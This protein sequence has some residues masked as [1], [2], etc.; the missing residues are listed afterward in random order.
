MWRLAAGNVIGCAVYGT[1]SFVIACFVG[2]DTASAIAS[3]LL[4]LSPLVLLAKKERL[5]HLRRDW[6]RAKGKLQGANARKFVTFSYYAFFFIVFWL[7]FEQVM[8]EMPDGIYTGGSQNL[9]DLPFHLGA[10]FSFTDGG[11]F[12]PQNPSFAGAKFSYPFIADVITAGFIKLGSDV[13]E[14]MFAQN[15]SWALSLLVLLDRFVAKLTGERSVGK[16]AVFLLFFSGGLGFILFAGDFHAQSKGFWEF[17]W[18]LPKDYTIG[19]NYSWGNSLVTLF[20]TQRSLLLGMPLTLL[21]LNFLWT[22]F[23]TGTD[24]SPELLRSKGLD[25]SSTGHEVHKAPPGVGHRG[26]M[27][28]LGNGADLARAFIVGLIAGCLPLI[29]LHSLAVVFVVTAFLFI[30]RPEQWRTW[31]S[32]GVGVSAIAVPELAWSLL[33]SASKATEFIGWH[34]GWTIKDENVLWFWTRNTGILIPLTILGVLIV[35]LGKKPQAPHARRSNAEMD[36]NKS[37]QKSL[38]FYLPFLFCFIIANITKLAPWEWDNIKVLIYWLLGSLPFIS[39]AIVWAWRQNMVLKVC[40]AMCFAAMIASGSLD[41]WRT[42][43]GQIKTRVFDKDTIQIADQIKKSTPANAVFLNAPTY[44]SAVVLTGRRSL[45]RFPGHLWSH[46]IDHASREED[47][48]RM[49][50]GVP[51]ADALLQEYGIDYVMISPLETGSLKVNQE[52]FRKFPVAA[53]SGQS[54]VYKVR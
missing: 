53:S 5:K 13:K 45:M 33:G 46:G 1:L 4:A 38:L 21:I 31:I 26:A 34:L 9:G 30:I 50:S 28:Q 43:S 8:Y 17:L 12:P 32:F 42:V 54:R 7:F 40:A 19:D 22:S 11:N 6:Q 15:F 47:V 44:N 51:G 37:G 23:V 36:Q 49:Y 3:F 52:F 16:I 48:K 24:E 2:L 27:D 41:V 18:H 20:I 25:S 39:I 35:Y 10:I 29:H 14:A